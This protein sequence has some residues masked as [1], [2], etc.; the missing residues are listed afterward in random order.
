MSSSVTI[1]S[2]NRYLQS[3][4]TPLQIL[5]NHFG[6][7]SFR[8]K[9]EAIISSVL[10]KNDTFALMPTGGGKSLCYQIPALIFEGLTLVISPLIALMKDQV[11]ALRINGIDAAYLNSTQ[12]WQEQDHVLNQARSGKL[13]LLYLA[14]EKLLRDNGAQ[15]A[16]VPGSFMNTLLSMKISL[17]AIDEAHCISHWGHD[18][19]P[20]YLMLAQ[21]KTLFPNVP[22]IALTA[23]ADRLTRKDIVD[24]LALNS[25]GVYVS[26]FNR[27]NI[28]YRVEPKSNSFDKLI[29]FL[30]TH[31]D[32]SGII[33]CLSRASTERVAE[34]LKNMGYSALAY[35]AG[36]EKEQ[37]AKHQEKFLKDETKIMVATIAFGMGID[38]SNVRFVVHMDLP[39]N[40]ESYYQETGRAGRD[41]LNSEALLFYS[42]ADVAKLKKF[43]TIEGK[44]E[45]TE[46]SFQKLDQMAAFG[47]LMSCR[48]KYL[49]NYFDEDAPEYCGNC[50]VCLNYYEP[51][52][53]TVH[54]QKVLSAVSRLNEKFGAGYIVDFLRGTGG[55]KI[56]NEHR[57]LKTFGIGHDTSKEDWNRIIR[58]L[59]GGGY[60][61][62]TAGMYPVLNLTEKSSGILKGAEMLMLARS[63]GRKDNHDVYEAEP[64][65]EVELYRKLK[66]IRRQ[67]AEE[68]NV[69]AYIILSDASLVE[70]ATYLPHTLEE[71]SQIS[72][73]GYTK[74]ERY[75]KHFHNAVETYCR[76]QQL[77]SRIHLKVPKR[78][79]PERPARET[80]TKLQ[81]YELFTRGYSVDAICTERELRRSTIED[82]LEFFLVTG[83]ISIDQLMDATKIEAIQKAL[84]NTNSGLLSPVR[85]LLGPDYSFGEIRWV[86]EH[87]KK[88]RTPS[89]EPRA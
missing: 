27:S 45:Q 86:R 61:V 35:H 67:L 74:L 39:K 70:L 20:E 22:V 77:T 11:D 23:T 84:E 32:D 51:Y 68:D 72:G 83:K 85:D 78:Q 69:P 14:P 57:E 89:H 26:S 87:L 12:S 36:M 8:L 2:H 3:N 7:E 81:T 41:G 10:D 25:P 15:S 28:R 4:M 82:H 42:Y 9:Q 76:A 5:R 29:T 53:G 34:D 71:L 62:K 33:Y 52:D 58:E 55:S 44:P 13:K 47:D 19:R 6:Y 17:I 66:D 46:I 49:L 64:S 38:K 80:D 30:E 37:R 43:A 59:V 40:I 48:R 65:Y 50:D 18:F 16:S 31:P 54:A 63:K 73:F 79:R 88:L 56:Q 24:K 1:L 21:L 75:G 60:L